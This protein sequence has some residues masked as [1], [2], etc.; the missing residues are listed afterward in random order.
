MATG[1]IRIHFLGN[2]KRLITVAE[3]SCGTMTFPM[4]CP[5]DQATG[6]ALYEKAG[7]NLFTQTPEIKNWVIEVQAA[8]Q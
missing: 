7:C 5:Q 6:D 2:R 8:V 3:E 1:L 4:S